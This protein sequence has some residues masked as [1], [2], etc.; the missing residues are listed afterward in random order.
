MRRVSIALGGVLVLAL[1]G[2]ALADQRKPQQPPAGRS[3]ESLSWGHTQTRP[4][5]ATAQGGGG[6]AG[7]PR[8]PGAA[9]IAGSAATT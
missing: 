6:D 5:G 4:L 8:G 1:C 7:V 9:S 2:Q 3:T